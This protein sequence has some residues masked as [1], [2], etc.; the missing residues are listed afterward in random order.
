MEPRWMQAEPSPK[1][2]VT[3]PGSRA[4]LAQKWR[5]CGAG[6][7]SRSKRANGLEQQTQPRPTKKC[8][9]RPR[10]LCS[11][12]VGNSVFG[13]T[14]PSKSYAWLFVHCHW[15][16]TQGTFTYSHTHTKQASKQ[17]KKTWKTHPPIRCN[18]QCIQ[19]EVAGSAGCSLELNSFPNYSRNFCNPDQIKELFRASVSSCAKWRGQPSLV[20]YCLRF[21]KL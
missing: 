4:N 5:R 11:V 3:D 7:V 13:L 19:T 20:S 10:S 6:L 14:T 1:V 21:W 18:S 2:L 16:Y 12:N 9:R 17:M 8:I 15:M